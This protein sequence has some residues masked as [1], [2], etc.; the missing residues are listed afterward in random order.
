M[1]YT[2]SQARDVVTVTSSTANSNY[3]YQ[4]DVSGNVTDN[5]LTRSKNDQPH[6]IIATGTYHMRTRTDVSFIYQGSSGSPYD[7]VYG[8]G[9]ANADGQTQNDLIYVPKDV[10]DP[11]EILFTGYNDPAKAASVATQQAAFDK[12]INS[13]PCLRESRG[14]ILSRN[15]CRSPWVNEVDV[16]VSQSLAAFH[17][18]NL[19]LRLDVINFGNLLNPKWGRQAFVSS[20]AGP[21][22]S[23]TNLLTTTGYVTGAV[24][25]GINP[26]QGIYTFDSSTQRYNAQNV[27]SNYSMQLSLRYS[28]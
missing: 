10:R 1:A 7:Y 25:N 18:Q 5:N 27:S 24:V 17:Q 22:S 20:G 26:V 9:D 6:R 12:F 19:A 8:S 13:V 21:Y 28:F 11:N 3:R 2:Y 4:R 15:A 16:S 23:A 14:K